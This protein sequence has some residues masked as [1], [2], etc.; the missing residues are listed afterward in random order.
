MTKITD[1]K[2]IDFNDKSAIRKEIDNFVNKYAYADTEYS[3]TISPNNHAYLLT[4]IKSGVDTSLLGADV[5]RD[6]ISI[7][8]HIVPKGENEG[9]SFSKRD[10]LFTAEYK[11]GKQYLVS[12]SRK[13]VFELI[14]DKYSEYDIYNAWEQA[15]LKVWKN[16][17]QA[18]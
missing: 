4:G 14:G 10:L 5:L 6:S 11:T 16:H 17:W 18:N 8:N 12:G 13:N 9:D 1:V 3:L 2:L 15:K 7:H